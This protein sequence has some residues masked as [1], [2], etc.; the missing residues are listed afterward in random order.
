MNTSKENSLSVKTKWAITGALTFILLIFYQLLSDLVEGIYT[1][2]LL[3]TQLDAKAAGLLFFFSSIFIWIIPFKRSKIAVRIVLGI[4]ML[5]RIIEP[6]MDPTGKITIA[7]I[8]VGAFWIGFPLIIRLYEIQIIQAMDT[9]AE[10]ARRF[11]SKIMIFALAGASFLSQSLRTWGVTL[12]YS[13]RGWGNILGVLI[14]LGGLILVYYTTNDSENL[15]TTEKPKYFFS[16]KKITVLIALITWS[17]F[18]LNA[19]AVFTRWSETDYTAVILIANLSTGAVLFLLVWKP[20]LLWK[21]KKWLLIT[22]FGLFLTFFVVG[23]V[24]NQTVFID[25]LEH[26]PIIVSPANFF[27]QLWIYLAC[28]LIFFLYTVVLHIISLPSRSQNRK[29]KKKGVWIWILNGFIMVL[30]IFMLIFTNVWGYVEPVSVWFLGLFWLPFGILGFIVAFALFIPL[31]FQKIKIKKVSEKIPKMGKMHANPSSSQLEKVITA[32]FLIIF[33]IL[34]GVLAYS[35]ETHPINPNISSQPIRSLRIMTY[36]VQQG[37]NVSGDKN[38]EQ[39]LAFVQEINPDIIGLEESDTPKINTGNTD[40]VRFFADKLDYYVYYG[41]KTVMQTYGVAILSRYPIQNFYSIFTYGNE[42][43]IGSLFA[44]VV[45]GN[46]V[47]NVMVNHPAGSRDAKMAHTD[48]MLDQVDE[49]SNVILM[50]DFNWRE[51]TDYYSMVTAIY[52]DSW[53]TKWPTGVD[54]QNLVMNSTIDHIFLSSTF[55]V[56][57]ARYII[58]PESQTDHPAYWIDISW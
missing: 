31:L 22:G 53:R 36:N 4:M 6:W 9:D 48:M 55:T 56:E 17:Y 21:M 2:D 26:S 47:F 18:A 27:Q 41:P 30:L 43:E 38:F 14:S 24:S 25:D 32:I 46:T 51:D 7:G 42:D 15:F 23:I 11:F 19:P 3:N 1:L 54:D 57:D 50:G 16:F 52:Q 33:I 39:Q 13:M 28:L 20:E 45:V 5:V 12:D 34:N 10:S 35:T 44:E 8:G 49:L 37:A 29:K 58:S 40:L